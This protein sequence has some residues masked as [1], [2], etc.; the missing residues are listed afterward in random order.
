M[1]VTSFVILVLFLQQPSFKTVATVA[2]LMTAIIIPSSDVIFAA[3]GEAP[4]T[5][6]DWTRIQ[7][8]ALALAESGNLL[9]MRPPAKDN[10]NWMKFSREMTDAA[11]VALKAARS[12]NATAIAEAGDR[13][14][15]SCESCHKQYMAQ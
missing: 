13:I 7:N 8:N 6:A 1:H 10:A 3:A 2:E 4:K 14:Y 9:L 12:K 5:D 11:E 15:G